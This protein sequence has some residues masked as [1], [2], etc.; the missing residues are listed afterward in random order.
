METAKERR[1]AELLVGDESGYGEQSAATTTAAATRASLPGGKR[2]ERREVRKRS[3]RFDKGT[4]K[5]G[6]EGCQIHE[7]R[8][9]EETVTRPFGS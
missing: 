5:F 4:A 3:H 1:P 9:S 6:C 2:E 7:S 8:V